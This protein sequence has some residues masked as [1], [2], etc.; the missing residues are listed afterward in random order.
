MQSFR[1]GQT[2]KARV[3][4]HRPMDGLVVLSLRP[5]VISQN[6][7]S[8]AEVEPG[9]VMAGK[10]AQVNEHGLIVTL[11]SNIK[12]AQPT[13]PSPV[14]RM[15][16]TLSQPAS[17]LSPLALVGH[18]LD[19]AQISGGSLRA[20]GICADRASVGPWQQS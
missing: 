11:T 13:C 20:Q 4:G 19:N 17:I 18:R 14:L 15:Q 2:V 3:V 8:H 7:T 1:V 12:C 10:V 6:L 5:S 9:A 16:G